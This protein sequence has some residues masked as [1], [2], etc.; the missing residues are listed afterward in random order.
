VLASVLDFLAWWQLP[1][2]AVVLLLWLWAGA[3]LLRRAVTPHVSRR[4]ARPAR[5]FRVSVLAALGT[6]VTAAAVYLLALTVLQQADAENLWL[7]GVAA[8]PFAVLVGC[9]VVWVSF[10]LPAG[11]AFRTWLA[12]FGPPFALTLALLVPTGVL[13]YRVRRSRINRQLCLLNLQRLH[14]VLYQHYLRA[15]LPP[16][17]DLPQILEDRFLRPGHL[18]CPAH[19]D[20]PIGYFYHPARVRRLGTP[21]SKQLFA[22]DLRGNHAGGRCAVF[23]NGDSGW[24]DHAAFQELLALPVN[25]EFAKELATAESRAE[26]P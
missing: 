5:C 14:R 4:H 15:G 10:D 21:G 11:P 19:D 8:V 16:P 3:L 20:R 24:F 18:R 23:L 26:L 2:A 13:S 25:R 6:G 22:C 1:V 17:T 12:A 9:L 7:P